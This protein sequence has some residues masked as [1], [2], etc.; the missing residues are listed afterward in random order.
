M[1]VS[2][3]LKVLE[4]DPDDASLSHIDPSTLDRSTD[5]KVQMEM[6]TEG[7]EKFQVRFFT[8]SDG[9]MNCKLTCSIS[10]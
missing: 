9:G 6:L 3:R 10:W 1:G 8:W 7:T 5:P 4:T 2:R